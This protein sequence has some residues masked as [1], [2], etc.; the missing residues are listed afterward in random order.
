MGDQNEIGVL[1]EEI[2]LSLEFFNPLDFPL[3]I[4]SMRLLS[5][6]TLEDGSKKC[7]FT[8]AYCISF[9]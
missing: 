7:I 6:L 8:N 9:L 1:G 5:S 2:V 4:N 3:E